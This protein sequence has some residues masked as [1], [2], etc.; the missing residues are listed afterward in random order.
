MNIRNEKAGRGGNPNQL[1]IKHHDTKTIARD[2]REINGKRDYAS[3]KYRLL[4]LHAGI[5]YNDLGRLVSYRR[6]HGLELGTEAAWAAVLANLTECFGVSADACSI[7]SLARRL[8]LPPIDPDVAAAACR[9]A[10]GIIMAAFVAGKLLQVLSC[11]RTAAVI[12]S[13]EAIDEPADARKRRLNRARQQ[14]RRAVTRH[15]VITARDTRRRTA[16]PALRALTSS[17]SIRLPFRQEPQPSFFPIGEGTVMDAPRQASEINDRAFAPQARLA[18]SR[19]PICEPF[20]LS[21]PS[22][23]EPSQAKPSLSGEQNDHL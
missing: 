23:P 16:S 5:R 9:S 19:P 3:E 11:E 6:R 20:D 4:K 7:N 2:R 10:D 13:L 8:G 22:N 15:K 17:S 14:K 1:N 21:Q 12:R 18:G